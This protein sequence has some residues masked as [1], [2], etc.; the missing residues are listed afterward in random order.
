MYEVGGG[1]A[2]LAENHTR[3]N[4]VQP[5]P[6]QFYMSSLA[7]QIQYCTQIRLMKK[8]IVLNL[9]VILLYYFLLRTF[10]PF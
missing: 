9:A 7:R 10:L 4:M 1:T 6:P 5:E 8:T 3:A 2:G